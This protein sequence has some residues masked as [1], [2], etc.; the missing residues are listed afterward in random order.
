MSANARR[1]PDD[2]RQRPALLY[3][4]GGDSWLDALD[5]NPADRPSEWAKIPDE[6]LER[7]LPSAGLR[8][9]EGPD[10]TVHVFNMHG[11][12]TPA[13]KAEI[14]AIARGHWFLVRNDIGG[15]ERLRCGR[16]GGKHP[17]FTLACVERPFHGLQ[18]FT[19]LLSQQAGAAPGVLDALMGRYIRPGSIQPITRRKAQQLIGRIRGRGEAI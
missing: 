9:V 15:V 2:D 13:Q 16:C 12:L 5:P 11:L 4:T 7:L 14:D 19:L 3:P 18:Q 10:G 1:A 6:V 8:E 17:Y